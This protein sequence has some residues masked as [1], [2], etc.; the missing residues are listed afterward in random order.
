M[1]ISTSKCFPQL[2][3]RFRLL[4]PISPMTERQIS[5]TLQIC[6]G[7]ESI[8]AVGWLSPNRFTKLVFPAFLDPLPM[9]GAIHKDE[10]KSAL[11]QQFEDTR[12]RHQE[13]DGILGVA[14]NSLYP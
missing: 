1:G 5:R 4:S 7:L 6:R 8:T 11:Q 13:V 14:M 2:W 3:Q 9:G 10:V 12:P